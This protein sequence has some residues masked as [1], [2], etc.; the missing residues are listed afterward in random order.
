MHARTLANW[1]LALLA[2]ALPLVGTLIAYP[3]SVQLGLVEA[4]NPFFEGCVSI[5]RAARHG[6]PNHLFR[7]LLLPAAALQALV[8]L[9][10]RVWLDPGDAAPT[11][12]ALRAL[13]WIGLTAAS[14]LVLYGSF[15][16]TEGDAYRW[17]RRY[18][19]VVYFGATCLA[20]LITTGALQTSR[21]RAHPLVRALLALCV[22]LPLLG[23]I[24][25]LVPLFLAGAGLR[26]ALQNVTEWWA[27]LVFTLFFFALA[28]LWRATRFE[29]RA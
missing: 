2:G 12:P 19:V 18:G 28:W 26:D 13:P 3:L 14:F 10:C 7:A 1:P 11:R 9:L 17:M 29:L 16:G 22:A 21:W 5:S 24:N 23:L 27:G 20:M 25:A 15:L 6:L 4:C 8:W